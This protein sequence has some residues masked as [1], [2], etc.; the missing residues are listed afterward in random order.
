MR[1]RCISHI[2][3]LV[4]QAF[5]FTGVITLEQLESYDEQEQTKQLLNNEARRVQF[6]LLGPLGKA[7]NIVVYIRSSP[8]RTAEWRELAG[9]MIPMDNRTRWNS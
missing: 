7:H 1:I 8:S 3:N 2:I 6:R 5:L 4:V 9:R